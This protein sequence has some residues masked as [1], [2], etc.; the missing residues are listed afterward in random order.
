M[1]VSVIIVTRNRSEKLKNCLY[2]LSKQTVF[3][4]ELIII[5]S[6]D[7]KKTKILVKKQKKSLKFKTT[8]KKIPHISI[9]YAR[10]Q[11]L[12]MVKK[13]IIAFTDDDCHPRRDWIQKIIQSHKE[14][15]NSAIIG[16][17]VINFFKDN[18]WAR[19]S[20]EM[21]TKSLKSNKKKETDFLLTANLS[22]K[23]EYLDRYNFIFDENLIGVE[24]EDLCKRFTLLG[25]KVLF[26]PKIIVEHDSR[27]TAFGFM[28]QWFFYGRAVY[29]VYNLKY[30][31]NFKTLLKEFLNIYYEAELKPFLLPFFFI[32]FFSWLSGLCYEY[33]L[34]N[35]KKKFY[36]ISRE[37]NN[38]LLFISKKLKLVNGYGYPYE[39]FI[40]P[41]N[42]CNAKCPLCP[43]GSGQLKRQK[44]FMDF[45][46]FKKIINEVK[47]HTKKIYLWNLGEPFLHKDI[48]K[49]IS[50]AK[51]FGLYVMSSTN[52][53][54]F[55]KKENIIN[56]IYS[57]LDRLIVCVDGIDQRTFSKYRKGLKLDLVLKGLTQLS[58]IK[59]ELGVDNPWI[60]FQ[61]IVMKHNEQQIGKFE[62]F[63]RENNLNYVLKKVN[64]E[65]VKNINYQ[66]WL[67]SNLLFSLY[68]I[69]KTGK[70]ILKNLGFKRTACELWKSLVVNWDGSINPCCY[71]Y[72]GIINLGNIKNHSLYS[73][74]SSEKLARMRVNIKTGNG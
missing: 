12:K 19:T 68:K 62:K 53:T 70:Y 15:P 37:I 4:D 44:G 57:G 61:F 25:E 40:E 13:G 60:D 2:S 54:V 69:S 66:E 46:L 22:I 30:G 73:I 52:G 29:L 9:P 3:P 38:L 10:N 18:Y 31:R 51:K 36:L 59:K 24:D 17:K 48:F 34:I 8:Y 27:E 55:Q 50:Y 6:S 1:K 33:I 35:P 47:A 63:A 58:K 26:E 39:L 74:W 65:M 11:G 20:C 71:D 5:D 23:K 67:P 16:G 32:G 41:T 45:E 43:T 56:L 21:I 14:N 7:D 64:L 72:G 28:K 42:I 49:M